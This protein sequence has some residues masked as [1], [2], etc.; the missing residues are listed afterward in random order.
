MPLGLL[1]TVP[2]PDLLTVKRWVVGVLLNVAVTVT[3]VLLPGLAGSVT[4]QGAVPVQA[5]LQPANDESDAGAAFKVTDV[6]ASNLF[7]H[8]APQSMPAGVEVTVPLPAP[9]L[10]TVMVTVRASVTVRSTGVPADKVTLGALPEKTF[11]GGVAPLK[12]ATVM[13]R[14]GP[15]GA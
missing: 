3:V 1:V 5:P 13:V 2:F 4:V 12:A 9:C 11:C 7:E 10:V 6:A 15:T 14:F 8:V